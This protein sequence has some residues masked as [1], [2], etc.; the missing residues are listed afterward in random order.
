LSA[1]HEAPVSV[2]AILDGA[3]LSTR[4]FYRHFASK[5]ELFLAMLKRDSDAVAWRLQRLADDTVGGPPAELAV[6]VDYF[7]GLAYHPRRRAHVVVLDSDEV[8]LAKGYREA[9]AELRS[10][11]EKIL[12]DILRRGRADGT[13]PLAEPDRDAAAIH[14]VV[15]RAFT[16]PLQ[17]L[18][19][20]RD[21]LVGYV[22][23]FALRAV[24]AR[25]AM[26]RDE[27]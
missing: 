13:F 5:D 23:D 21:R 3:G 16:A 17:D 11:R 18:G 4:A 15:D 20:D 7:L 14:A 27:Y 9:S 2:A 6:W 25:P 19:F 1:P 12:A 10:D 8:R 26:N 24:G 22:V